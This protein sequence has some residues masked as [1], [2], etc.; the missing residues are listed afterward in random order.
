MPRVLALS[1]P[2]VRYRPIADYGAIG[3]GRSVALI[4]SDGSLDW[5]C[6]GRF[7]AP[8]VFTRILDAGAGGHYRVAPAEASVHTSM[9][10][11]PHTNVLETTHRTDHGAVRVRDFLAFPE[12]TGVESSVLIRSIVG[13]EGDVEMVVHFAPRFQYGRVTPRY[14]QAPHHITFARGAGEIMMFRGIDLAPA[15]PGAFEGRVVVR[16]G[17]RVDLVLRHRHVDTPVPFRD[18]LAS[19]PDKL[20]EVTLQRWRDWAAGTRIDGP[21]AALVRRSALA[22]KLLHHAP[23]GA[24]VAAAT[25]SLPEEVGGVRNWDYRFTWVRDAVLSAKALA[26]VGHAA[27]ADAL[28]GWLSRTVH[29]ADMRIMYTLTG[30]TDLPEQE[31]PHL[32]GYRASRPVRIGNGAVTQRQ[33]DVYGELFEF[34]EA[35]GLDDARWR[36]ALRALA[37]WVVEHWREPDSGIWEMRSEPRH[38]VL[39]KAMAWLALR[40]AAGMARAGRMEGDADRWEKEAELVRLDVMQNGW[41]AEM[42]A[43][44]QAYGHKLLDASNLMLPLIGFIDARH[45]RMLATVDRTLEKL[46]ANGLVYR[47][48][49][50]GDGIEGGEATFAYCSFWLVEVLA[51]QGRVREARA[52]FDGLAE[53]ASPLGLYAEEID[54]TSG[55]HLGNY[56][57]GFPHAGLIQAA[58]ALRKAET[59]LHP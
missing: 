48:L 9:R 26:A 10:Y 17:E 55:A 18:A 30:G 29:G 8:S 23:T 37:E 31:L 19:P 24:I 38:F 27:E 22:L 54:P 43:F 56:P 50:A 25:T 12:D 28:A 52:L 36:E 40:K 44:A 39:S 7:D 3:E 49:D 41:D 57:Q 14:S 34:A 53:R 33:L 11:V 15:G 32:E 5:W 2:G 58:L 13:L 42:G 51:M 1:P 20:E 21:D 16:A 4:G 45:P 47:Y 35:H 46:T 59:A 6:P